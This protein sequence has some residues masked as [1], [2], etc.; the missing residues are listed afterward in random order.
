MALPAFNVLSL[1]SGIGGLD[2]GLRLA[3]PQA[4]TVCYA[5][6][7][8]YPAAVLAARIADGALDDAPIWSDLRRFDG[9]PWRGVV[10]CIIG[11]YPC[12]PFSLAGK[13]L[14]TRDPRFV[15]PHICGGNACQLVPEQAAFAFRLLYELLV[16][17]ER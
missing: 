14:G 15:W 8:V 7:E 1:C 6:R 9:Q 10:D 2:L 5:E 12:Q 16:G 3:L 4:R 17:D 11:G 13:R